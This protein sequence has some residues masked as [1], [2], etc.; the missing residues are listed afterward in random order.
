MKPR[1][2]SR[3]L[4]LLIC[5]IIINYPQTLEPSQQSPQKSEPVNTPN[6]LNATERQ[7]IASLKNKLNVLVKDKS[8]LRNKLDAAEKETANLK[9]KLFIL[10]KE[11]SELKYTLPTLKKES[12]KLNNR[13]GALEK[14]KSILQDKV[15]TLERKNDILGIQSDVLSG[16]LRNYKQGITSQGRRLVLQE[17]ASA[18]KNAHYNLGYFYAQKGNVDGAIKE[19]KA[20]IQYNPQDKDSHYNLACL[21]GLKGNFKEAIREFETVLR[22]DPKDRES[23]YNLANI[24]SKNLKDADKAEQYY[25]KFLENEPD[26]ESQ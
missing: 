20:A 22:L 8:L 23:Y 24:Y 26:K 14:E 21:Y 10:K 25:R 5:F 1:V 9:K 2:F 3:V 13:L 15:T 16:R 11:K 6:K 7:E 17:P 19:Y 4:I 18:D 12:D